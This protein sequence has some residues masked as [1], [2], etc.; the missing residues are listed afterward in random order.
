M[1]LRM[2]GRK[3]LRARIIF[4]LELLPYRKLKLEN[5]PE[6][7]ATAFTPK[8]KE[9]DAIVKEFTEFIE[10]V[11]N[12]QPLLKEADTSLKHKHP[13]FGWINAVEWFALVEIH[14]RHHTRQKTRIEK[15]IF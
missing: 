4:D 15:Q 12:L 8:S 3:N 11:K 9:K 2:V 6:E 14:I 1:V 10:H 7:I 5:F 13:M